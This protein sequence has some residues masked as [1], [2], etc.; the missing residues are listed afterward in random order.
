MSDNI[1]VGGFGVACLDYIAASN[2]PDKNNQSVIT[3]YKT[4]L[5]GLTANSIMAAGRLG[6][7]TRFCSV[8]GDDAIAENI[9]SFLRDENINI[10]YLVTQRGKNSHFSFIV[11]DNLSGERHIYSR[12]AD[13]EFSV[14]MIDPDFLI[15]CDVCLVDSH[16]FEGAKYISAAAHS[17][18][19][20][21]VADFKINLEKISLLDNVDYPIISRD[22]ALSLCDDKKLETALF[23][24][25]E[26]NTDSTP[27]ITC[28]S[29]GIYYLED[30]QVKYIPAF[31]VNAVDT[32]GAGDIFHGAFAYSIAMEYSLK[33][34]LIFASAAA[35]IK[36]MFRG[37]G[38]GAPRSASE[39]RQFLRKY[40]I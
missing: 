17:K 31:N 12:R 14:D 20:P 16:W 8:L 22:Y 18:N 36:C 9:K 6:A 29:D 26:Q 34:S 21:V 32:T 7:D 23:I 19:I 24:M 33:E 25:K 38:S 39:V 27:I 10:D 1:L 11:V 30:D 40:N 28:G 35:A 37:G 3:D 2:Q 15:G 13:I 4:V 5:G